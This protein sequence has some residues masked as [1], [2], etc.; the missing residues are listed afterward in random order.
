MLELQAQT[1]LPGDKQSW[2]SQYS[3]SEGKCN[4]QQKS[5][6]EFLGG[7]KI[8]LGRLIFPRL[9]DYKHLFLFL[10]VHMPPETL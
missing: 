10:L 9:L 3:T 8:K 1:V 2:R 6:L 5:E 7:K 4:R